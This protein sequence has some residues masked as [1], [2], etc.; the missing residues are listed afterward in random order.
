MTAIRELLEGLATSDPA[1]FAEYE[2]NYK[3]YLLPLDALV[4]VTVRDGDLD[5]ST[6]LVTVK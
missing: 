5:R 4:Q 6:M 3:P 1:A 2:Q